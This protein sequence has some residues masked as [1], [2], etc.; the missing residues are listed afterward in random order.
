M[1]RRVRV[2]VPVV[3][4]YYDGGQLICVA[5]GAVCLLAGDNR[6]Y[7]PLSSDVIALI[8]GKEERNIVMAPTMAARNMVYAGATKHRSFHRH[9][10]HG[11]ERVYYTPIRVEI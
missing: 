2:L 5:C 3:W 4:I 6:Y 1:V 7:S 11:D 9:H 8:L 10:Q